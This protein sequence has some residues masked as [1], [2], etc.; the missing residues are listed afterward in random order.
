MSQPNVDDTNV[1]KDI[2]G[3]GSDKQPDPGDKQPTWQE[4]A[5]VDPSE[6]DTPEKLAKA[7]KDARKG[8]SEQGQKVKDLENFKIQVNPLVEALMNDKDLYQKVED[9]LKKKDVKTTTDDKKEPII[10]GRVDDISELTEKQIIRDF[11]KDSG[12]DKLSKEKQEEVRK[13]VGKYMAEMSGGNYSLK[14]LPTLLNYAFSIYKD[15]QGFKMPEQESDL[16]VGGFGTPSAA[17]AATVKR[18]SPSQLSPEQQK[19][20]K[21]MG[22]TPDEYLEQ[23]KAITSS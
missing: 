14:S 22:L 1:N 17:Y 16:E 11:E 20:A 19:A 10:D 9:H 21:G 5:G 7:Y 8:L 3:E 23:L 12:I 13:G 6:F 4:M 2:E 15:K 18:M